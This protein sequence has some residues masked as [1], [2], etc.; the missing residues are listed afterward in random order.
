MD[1]TFSPYRIRGA[2]CRWIQDDGYTHALT[3]NTDRELSLGRIKT[4]FGTFCHKIDRA[5][6]GT[7]HAKRA[8]AHQRIRAV[9]FPE[10]L[11]TN[12]HLHIAADLTHALAAMSDEARLSELIRC[13]WLQS[14][15]GFGSVDVQ[16]LTGSGWPFYMTK[17]FRA[18]DHPMLFA[19]D[20]HPA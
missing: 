18:P 1:H 8:A 3:L 11:G 19:S 15:R 12:A 9:A 7:R 4:I 16:R 13:A 14:N 20:Y 17:R 6:L 2:L 10:N 5:V